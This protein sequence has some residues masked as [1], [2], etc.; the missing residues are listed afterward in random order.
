MKEFDYE[1]CEAA[2]RDYLS[3]SYNPDNSQVKKE[4]DIARA[5]VWATLSVARAIREMNGEY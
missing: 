1:E 2:A 5:Q 4:L 3:R